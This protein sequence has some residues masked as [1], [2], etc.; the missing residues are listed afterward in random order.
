M[1]PDRFYLERKGKDSHCNSERQ[2]R[3]RID[4]RQG[5]SDQ[6]SSRKEKARGLHC[7]IEILR[8]LQWKSDRNFHDKTPGYDSEESSIKI[9]RNPGYVEKTDNAHRWLS[10]SVLY[11]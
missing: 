3:Q 6:L 2:K 9:Q 1:E 11:K 10:D 5:L 7:G 8:K 4:I